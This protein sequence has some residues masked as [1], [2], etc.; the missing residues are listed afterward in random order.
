MEMDDGLYSTDG[1]ESGIEE[2]ADFDTSLCLVHGIGIL[3]LEDAHRLST[4]K[5]Q[6]QYIFYRTKI[7]VAKAHTKGAGICEKKRGMHTFLQGQGFQ[8]APIFFF[9]IVVSFTL[10]DTRF[11]ERGVNLPLLSVLEVQKTM[12]WPQGGLPWWL[13]TGSTDNSVDGKGR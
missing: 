11:P 8:T 4:N 10:C 3:N 7:E 2:T 1:S 13:V 12:R 5:Q 9:R 6:Y